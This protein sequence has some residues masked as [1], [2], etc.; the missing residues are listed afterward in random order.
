M[1][2]SRDAPPGLPVIGHAY[3][4]ARDPLGFVER[5]VAEYGG[6]VR[7]SAIKRDAVLLA[8]PA[9]IERVL[10]SNADNYRKG[11]FQKRE[12]EGLLG[13]GLLISEGERWSR[14]RD[15]IQPAFYPGRIAS[16]AETM[17]ECTSRHLDRWADRGSIDA[18]EALPA[19]TLDVLG[20]VLFGA[21]LRDA[22]EVREA[23]AA[24][25]DRFAPDSRTPFYVPDWV[26][27]ARNRRYRRAVARLESFVADLAD[28]RRSGEGDDDLLSTLVESGAGDEEIRDQLITFLLAGHETTALAL[29]Y[30]LF[31]LG[32][33]PDEQA[34]VADEIRDLDRPPALGDDLPRTDRAIREAMRLYPPVPVVMREAVGDDA[35]AGCD[36]PAGA[37][38]LCSQ[39]ATHRRPAFYDDPE[40]F[41]PERWIDDER[42]AYAYFPF[43]GGP[44]QCIGRRFALVEA[45]LVL[46]SVLRRFRVRTAAPAELDLVASMTLAPADTVELALRERG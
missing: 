13:D 40:A 4:Y 5:T 33:H 24:V 31:L 7:L 15:R 43:G 37:L 23:A 29:T 21:D 10:A 12:L 2:E 3:D 22:T 6:A 38:V 27:T 19:L 1:S 28:S 35:V 44:R 26:P 16:Y 42:P 14:Q 41:R 17:V 20:Q 8:D 39:W 32:T 9:A 34:R 46:A 36:V 18:T 25:T 30:A 11:E 45:R